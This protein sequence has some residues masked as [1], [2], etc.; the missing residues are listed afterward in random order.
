MGY[1]YKAITD[2]IYTDM[3]DVPVHFFQTKGAD[4]IKLVSTIMAQDAT[5]FWRKA[6]I[7]NLFG[8]RCLHC[9]RPLEGS[10]KRPYRKRAS[11]EV[12]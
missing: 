2:S 1:D 5:E 4:G 10:E 7:G 11:K 3:R 8:F 9:K 6:E 12:I